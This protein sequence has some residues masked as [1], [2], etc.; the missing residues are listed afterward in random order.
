MAKLMPNWELLAGLQDQVV[1]GVDEVGRGAWAGPVVAAAVVLPAGRQLAGLADS[2]LL[3]PVMRQRLDRIIR[4][5]AVA[6]GLG[7]VA[8]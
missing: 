6:V 8:A 7:W 5:Q 2:K 3:P 1:A 4:R